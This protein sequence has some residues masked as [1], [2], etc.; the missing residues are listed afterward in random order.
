MP[1]SIVQVKLMESPKLTTFTTADGSIF[2][3]KIPKE[4]SNYFKLPYLF[5]PFNNAVSL[6][7]PAALDTIHL[8][9]PNRSSDVRLNVSWESLLTLSPVLTCIH[10]YWL[11]GPPKL[12]QLK[13]TSSPNEAS[14]LSGVMVTLPSGETGGK[15]NSCI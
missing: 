13:E 12:V 3:D 8:Y 6:S 9:S 15:K 1:S 2:T 7:F 5:L 4:K 11:S 14:I 10:S